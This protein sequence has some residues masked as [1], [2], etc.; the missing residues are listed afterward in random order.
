MELT[1]LQVQEVLGALRAIGQQKFPA[2]FAWKLQT[3]RKSLEAPAQTLVEAI[4]EIQQKYAERDKEGK[5]VEGTNEKGETVPGSIKIPAEKIAEAN[6]ELEE[7]LQEKVKVENVQLKVSD[8]PESAEVT[9]DMLSAL[10]PI[11]A[12]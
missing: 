1:N 6:K 5:L 11:M 7:L 9:V 2:K 3:A 10:A 8:F 12:E 4:Q